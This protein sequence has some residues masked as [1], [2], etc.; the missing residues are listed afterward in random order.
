[1]DAPNLA[2]SRVLIGLGS[3]LG[4]RHFYLRRA[5]Y[6]LKKALKNMTASSI[7]ESEALVPKGAPASWKKPYLNLVIQGESSLS[8]EALLFLLKD[9]EKTLGRQ[10]KE[11]WSPRV[12]D[13]DLLEIGS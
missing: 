6:S 3:N 4:D 11:R 5:F 9:L 12:I 7:Y 2:Q 1:M 8:P 13:L 10:K